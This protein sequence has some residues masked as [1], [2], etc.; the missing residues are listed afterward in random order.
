MIARS[1]NSRVVII[2]AN[3][4]GRD[5]GSSVAEAQKKVQAQVQLPPGYK[6]FWGGQ[7][8]NQQRANA[9]LSVAIPITIGVIFLILYASFRRVRDTLIIMSS[10]PLAA[11]GGIAALFLSHT[12]FSVS[13]GVGFIAAAGVSVQNGVIILTCIKQLRQQGISKYKAVMQG[14]N[15]KLRPVIMAGTVAILGLLPAAL[16]NGIGSQS[17]KPFAIVIIGGLLTST[18][19]S[20]LVIPV[21]YAWLDEHKAH[22]LKNRSLDL[23]PE[24]EP[25]REAVILSQESAL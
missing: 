5:L 4:R 10:V 17:Q 19:L 8:E 3:V 18:L 25:L 23:H 9:R 16:S 2:K 12:Y 22:P 15:I 24:P 21:L 7:F 14:A 13:A 6:I 1:D 11:I 20:I